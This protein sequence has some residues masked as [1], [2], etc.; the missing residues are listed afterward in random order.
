MTSLRPSLVCAVCR[1]EILVT[2][3]RL[4]S[5]CGK[6]TM[7]CVRRPPQ[8]Y[9]KCHLLIFV[10]LVSSWSVSG[11]Q[12][13][14]FASFSKLMYQT[15]ASCDH[16][17]GCLVSALPSNYRYNRLVLDA[18][19]QTRESPFAI[20]WGKVS[21]SKILWGAPMNQIYGDDRKAHSRSDCLS[22]WLLCSTKLGLVGTIDPS[23]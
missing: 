12:E 1:T 4:H 2:K 8:F 21:L 18:P 13:I 20:P 3:R 9:G 5:H 10:S 23:W 22:A 17:W 15:Q 7:S 11:C 19:S 14:D 6:L 16:E